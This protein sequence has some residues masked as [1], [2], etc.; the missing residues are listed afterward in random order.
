MTI[1]LGTEWT[2]GRLTRPEPPYST[3][4][5]HEGSLYSLRLNS[6]RDKTHSLGVGRLLRSVAAF[7][8]LLS[9][10]DSSVSLKIHRLVPCLVSA[11][12]EQFAESS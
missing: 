8:P 9:S 11:K 2:E 10:V 6:A 4:K 7:S 1:L 12:S 5:S 3:D